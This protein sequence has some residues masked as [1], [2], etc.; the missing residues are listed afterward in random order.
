MYSACEHILLFLSFNPI[1]WLKPKLKPNICPFRQ[2]FVQC[3]SQIFSQI[4]VEYFAETE[5]KLNIRLLPKPKLIIW[6][7]VLAEFWLNI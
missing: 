4:L 5:L 3:A 1:I 2:N 6:P 7:K